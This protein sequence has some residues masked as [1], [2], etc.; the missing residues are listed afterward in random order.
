M[1]L[2]ADVSLEGMERAEGGS[3]LYGEIK[4]RYGNYSQHV[5]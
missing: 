2:L 1:V 4:M 3:V 5:C